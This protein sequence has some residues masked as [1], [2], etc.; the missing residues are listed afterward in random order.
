[1][2]NPKLKLIRVAPLPSHQT[3]Q[4]FQSFSKIKDSRIKFFPIFLPALIVAMTHWKILFNNDEKYS[5]LNTR[6]EKAELT[7]ANDIC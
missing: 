5:F 7:H 2:K 6:S 1:V 3:E 4:K